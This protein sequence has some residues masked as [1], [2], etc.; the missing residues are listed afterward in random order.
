MHILVTG[1]AGF[2]GSHLVRL[3]LSNGHSVT[4]VDDVSTGQV[5]NITAFLDHPKFRF[6]RAD[7]VTWAGLQDAAQAADMIYHLAAVVGVRRVLDDPIRVLSTNIVGTERLLGAMSGGRQPPRL[8]FASSSEVYGFNP[9]PRIAETDQLVYTSGNWT[10]RSYAVSKLAGEH[11]ASAYAREHGMQIIS[12]RF[13]NIIGPRQRGEYGMVLPNFVHQAVRGLPITVYGD[14][15][16][17]RS[18]C[19]VR[20]AVQMMARLAGTN[21]FPGEIV[22]LGN[23]EEITINDLAELVRRRANSSSTI[24][25]LSHADGYGEHFDDAANRRPDLTLLKTMVEFCPR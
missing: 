20:D 7:I 16:Q 5:D 19:D 6:D 1:G 2:I 10:R 8:M 21:P 18:F 4:A 22:N 11:F 14:G 15:N 9:S 23:D 12:L 24:Q 17:T 13:F 3:L 25:H